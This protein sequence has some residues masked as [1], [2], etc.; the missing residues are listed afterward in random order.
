MTRFTCER[1]LDSLVLYDRGYVWLCCPDATTSPLGNVFQD[2]LLA[3]WR[4][5][6]ARQRR[7]NISRGDFSLCG[8][9]PHLPAPYGPISETDDAGVP[10][11]GRVP[12]LSVSFDRACNLCCSSCRRE[13]RSQEVDVRGLY[14]VL[15]RSGWLAEVDSL[16][17]LGSGDPFASRACLDFLGEVPWHAYPRLRLHL[18][19]NGLL[20]NQES[21]LALGRAASR[22]SE[23]SVS[24]DADLGAGVRTISGTLDIQV[25]PGEAVSVGI[26]AGVPEP[27]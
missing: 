11:V 26:V 19:T 8:R 16:R 6:R 3:L 22:V 13:S 18:Q 17:L 10:E 25:E 7:A 2:D 15:L 23:V 27:Q 4:G 21:Y 14:D 9:C 5:P 12:M 1:A 20:L 24:V